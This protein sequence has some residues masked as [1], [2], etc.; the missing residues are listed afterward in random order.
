MPGCTVDRALPR[1]TVQ[2]LASPT[3]RTSVCNVV[4]PTVYVATY[5]ASTGTLPMGQ[6]KTPLGQRV[7]RAMK[8][9]RQEIHKALIM[10]FSWYTI[11]PRW[12]PCRGPTPV[13]A[14][15]L[16]YKR[17]TPVREELKSQKG[18][19]EAEGRLIHE[20][21]SNRTLSGRRVLR[22][23][24]PNHSKSPCVLVFWPFE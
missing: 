19:L 6:V 23:G 4:D 15:P 1:R 22:S 8:R 13:Y 7:C 9:I 11:H 16:R 14:P 12:A 5:T 21:K 2:P 10:S 20:H 3:P 18:D 24:G 17:E